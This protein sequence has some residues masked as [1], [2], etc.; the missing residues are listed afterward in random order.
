MKC[1]THVDV[2]ASGF[3]RNCGKPLCHE[4]ARDVR[5]ALYCEDCL[6]SA[7]AGNAVGTPPPRANTAAAA[8]LGLIPGLGAVYN[9]DYTRA[10]IH[11]AIWAGLMAV[12]LTEAFG[13]LTPLAWIAFGMFP[14]YTSLDS[15]RAAQGRQ[16]AAPGVEGAPAAPTRP[17]GAFVLI[18]LGVLALLG[19]LG[20]INGDWV[21]RGWPV[22]LIAIGVWLFWK[23]SQA[24]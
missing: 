16:V 23:R 6:A 18:G 5:G 20:L 4:C 2:D 24:S 10:L 13:N 8:A 1:A 11:V 9:G 15:Y 3:C 19:N 14:I 17:V 12:G 22:I 21:N 7:L